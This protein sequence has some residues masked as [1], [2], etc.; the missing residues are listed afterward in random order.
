MESVADAVEQHA[1]ILEVIPF[2]L[3]ISYLDCESLNFTMGFDFNYRGNQNELLAEALGLFPAFDR[4]LETEGSAILG[5]EPLIQ[6][7]LDED[8]KTQCRVSFETRTTA[9]QVRSG[10]YGDE[11]LSVF[12]T[13]RRYDSLSPGEDFATEFR[14]LAAIGE[15]LVDSFLTDNIL[16]PLQQTIALK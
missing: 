13:V 14:R 10:E 12:L 16:R 6:L 8:C 9:Y 11:P 2:A 7:A 3:S 15:S 1:S 4:L 5:Y